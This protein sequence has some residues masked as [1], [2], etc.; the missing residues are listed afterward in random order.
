MDGLWVAMKAT[1]GHHDFLG[2]MAHHTASPHT[3]MVSV[4]GSEALTFY[5]QLGEGLSPDGSSWLYK[6]FWK[7]PL[8]PVGMELF[9]M[10][11]LETHSFL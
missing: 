10:M 7:N 2:F 1:P 9:S 4:W 3:I 6:I 5:C 11:P 8:S